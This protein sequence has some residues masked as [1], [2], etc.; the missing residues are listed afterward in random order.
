LPR[1][2]EV[3]GWVTAIRSALAVDPDQ[4]PTAEEFARALRQ[5][6]Q[7]VPIMFHGAKVDLRAFI[8]RAVRR[9]AANN[10]DAMANGGHPAVGRAPAPAHTPAVTV[11]HGARTRKTLVGV[12]ATAVLVICTIVTFSQLA[13][14]ED[15]VA[16]GP[17]TYPAGMSPRTLLLLS[18]ARDAS[19]AWL[20]KVGTGDMTA[21]EAMRGNRVI[22]TASSTTPI[23]CGYLVAN[24]A[25]LLP[26]K[27]VDAMR[28]ATVLEVT[29]LT[30]GPL[31]PSGT[32]PSTP[33]GGDGRSGSPDPTSRPKPA[34]PTATT[35]PTSENGIGDN[36]IGDEGS[37]LDAYAY[38][39]LPFVPALGSTLHR[40]EIT[41]TYHNS[42]WWVASVVVW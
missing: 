42:H 9:L 18:G 7:R 13:G 32:L 11:G 37:T 30:L 26:A 15:A 14:T 12:A 16:N 4:R 19:Q 22:T 5:P 38:V 41:M 1:G 36:G 24:R 28:S 23:S 25:V 31:P 40:L 29:G 8:P 33:G 10:I 21:C 35:S 39:S 3:P 6:S 20:Q 27:A 34:P 17:L 2:P